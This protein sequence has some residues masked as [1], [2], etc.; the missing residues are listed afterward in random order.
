[1]ATLNSVCDKHG[2]DPGLPDEPMRAHVLA[3]AIRAADAELSHHGY[4]DVE[5][6]EVLHVALED[7]LDLPDDELARFEAQL[8]REH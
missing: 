7:A 1:M 5:S 8:P 2:H 3:A 4:S 6:A